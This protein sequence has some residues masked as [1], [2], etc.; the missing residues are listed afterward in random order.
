[1]DNWTVP[2]ETVKVRRERVFKVPLRYSKKR[3]INLMSHSQ[4]KNLLRMKVK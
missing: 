2:T 4:W 1:M 3:T